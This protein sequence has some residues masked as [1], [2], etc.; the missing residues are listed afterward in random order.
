M[1]ARRVPAAPPPPPPDPAGPRPAL[2]QPRPDVDP[3]EPPREVSPREVRRPVTPIPA[4]RPRATAMIAGREQ[5]FAAQMV[6]GLVGLVG[7]SPGFVVIVFGS[8]SALEDLGYLVL[9]IGLLA[10]CAYQWTLLAGTGQTVGKR[11]VGIRV[12]CL[13]GSPP[14]FWTMVVLRQW[15]LSVFR[16]IPGGSV[17]NLVDVA[18]IFSAESR[19]VHD[20]IAGTRVV[21]A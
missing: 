20:Y 6:D 5:R 2:P 10:V 21:V 9:A 12:E 19:C 16:I 4:P 3:F 11:A 15:A 17:V 8:G 13:D 18:A 1:P 14:S 7:V